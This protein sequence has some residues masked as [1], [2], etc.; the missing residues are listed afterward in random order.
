MCRVPAPSCVT[1]CITCGSW[2]APSSTRS[3]ARMSDT[4]MVERV[5]GR[6]RSLQGGQE[7]GDRGRGWGQGAGAQGWPSSGY[8]RQVLSLELGTFKLVYL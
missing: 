1:T 6:G 4:G 5:W 3:T 2:K 7:A 8:V